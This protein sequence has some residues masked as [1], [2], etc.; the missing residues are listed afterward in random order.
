MDLTDCCKNKQPSINVTSAPSTSSIA[1][2]TTSQVG[3]AMPRYKS[4]PPLV[5]MPRIPDILRDSNN[6]Q[7]YTLID[8][9]NEKRHTIIDQNNDGRQICIQGMNN[10][11]HVQLSS[12]HQ[13]SITHQPNNRTYI[14]P[15]SVKKMLPS[16]TLN[17]RPQVLNNVFNN[18]RRFVL[19]TPNQDPKGSPVS[20]IRSNSQHYMIP[21]DQMPLSETENGSNNEINR[22]QIL[23]PER[24][25]TVML[26]ASDKTKRIKILHSG[27]LSDGNKFTFAYGKNGKVIDTSSGYELGNPVRIYNASKINNA[28]EIVSNGFS[29]N[30]GNVLPIVKPKQVEMVNNTSRNNNLPSILL[31]KPSEITSNTIGNI[32][33]ASSIPHDFSYKANNTTENNFTTLLH[34]QLAGEPQN[35]SGFINL[36][37]LL[38]RNPSEKVCNTTGSNLSPILCYNLSDITDNTTEKVNTPSV[39][40]SKST[41]RTSSILETMLSEGKEKDPL[42]ISETTVDED[43]VIFIDNDPDDE[44]NDTIVNFVDVQSDDVVKEV[45]ITNILETND[46]HE[47]ITLDKPKEQ[48]IV[49]EPPKPKIKI[50]A[51]EE[52]V[53]LNVNKVNED[54]RTKETVKTNCLI[55]EQKSLETTEEPLIDMKSLKQAIDSVQRV[56]ISVI[57]SIRVNRTAVKSYDEMKCESSM[58]A[59]YVSSV[60]DDLKMC[61]RQINVI[62]SNIYEYYKD[63]PGVLEPSSVVGNVSRTKIKKRKPYL[64]ETSK[65][66]IVEDNGRDDTDLTNNFSDTNVKNQSTNYLDNFTKFL[67]SYESDNPKFQNVAHKSAVSKKYHSRKHKPNQQNGFDDLNFVI[68]DSSKSKRP[69][70]DFDLR[71]RRDISGSPIVTEDELRNQNQKLSSYSCKTDK[72]LVEISHSSYSDLLR[73]Y[74]IKRCSVLLHQLDPQ[75]IR[76]YQTS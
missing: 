11:G 9:N 26:Q 13:K 40:C 39:V 37:S 63:V 20:V 75:L 68:N 56:L 31:R 53:N 1:L 17:P 55:D 64:S 70:L 58:A 52:L 38:N 62:Q 59:K 33:V 65:S 32:N 66:V 15:S 57:K 12:Q 34:N 51:I 61:T 47:V 49:K 43:D 2:A 60:Q 29:E 8:E 6:I 10:I 48:D 25:Q 41:E 14:Y 16:L 71:N 28:Q 44:L 67:S 50:K 22:I 72:D 35:T 7:N 76:L 45:N 24:T 18:N 4:P 73:K 21:D 69:K 23:N 27:T 42:A 3:I 54:Q 36:L 5:P 19:V 46:L 30:V 74:K